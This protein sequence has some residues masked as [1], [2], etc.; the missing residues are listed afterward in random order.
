[1]RAHHLLKFNLI[2]KMTNNKESIM[3]NYVIVCIF[4]LS[5]CS[6]LMNPEGALQPVQVSDAKQQLM[7]TTC[8]GAVEDWGSCNR[9]ANKSC[10]KGYEIVKKLETPIGGK[11]E[12]TFKCQ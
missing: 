8:S 9:K 1:M 7:F 10:V 3:Q 12:L 6:S 11:R 4:F 5:A 2:L